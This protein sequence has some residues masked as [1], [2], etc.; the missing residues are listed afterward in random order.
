MLRH[1]RPILMSCLVLGCTP[2]IAAS[3]PF[4]WLNRSAV[5]NFSE[6]DW[7]VF[8][9]TARK[10]LD[11]GAQGT[12][13]EWSNSRTG[14][15][16]WITVMESSEYQGLRCRRAVF[17]NRAGGITGTQEHRLCKVQDG[18]WKIAP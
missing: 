13:A 17:Y 5:G 14:A 6:D 8:R 12:K 16:G 1:A 3:G 10:A 2:A 15:H 11:E 7:E 18:T 4:E 9:T